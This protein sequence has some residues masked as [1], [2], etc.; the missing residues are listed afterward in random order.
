MSSVAEI[1]LKIISELFQQLILFYFSFRPA[2]DERI[3]RICKNRAYA[4]YTTPARSLCF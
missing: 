1:I 2:G 3:K 4:G